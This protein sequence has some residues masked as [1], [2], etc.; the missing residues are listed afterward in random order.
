[1]LPYIA[2]HE[3]EVKRKHPEIRE[4]WVAAVLEHPYHTETQDDGRIHYYGY[5]AE[6]RKWLLGIMGGGALADASGPADR[7]CCALGCG[8]PP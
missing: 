3:A 6:A 4:E 1:M 2:A 8:L 5:I 7:R